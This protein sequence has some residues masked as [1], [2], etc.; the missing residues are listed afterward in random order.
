[1]KSFFWALSLAA[2][3]FVPLNV[4]AENIYKEGGFHYESYLKTHPVLGRSITPIFIFSE[5]REEFLSSLNQASFLES[6]IHLTTISQYFSQL[7][8]DAKQHGVTAYTLG[9][10][11]VVGNEERE[12]TC[13]I[14][15]AHAFSRD[16]GETLIHEAMHCKTFSDIRL[17][18]SA[19]MKASNLYA[20]TSEL[21]GPQFL[22]L[23]H[24]VLA[25]YLQISFVAN[26]LTDQGDL[27]V[28]RAAAAKENKAVSIGY[29][30]ARNALDLCSL[31]RSCPVETEEIIDLILKSKKLTDST[32][33]DIMELHKAAVKSGYVFA[34][35]N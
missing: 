12:T 11:A 4:A 14:V 22:S 23:F 34:D 33:A 32:V 13:G 30:T 28:K 3:G 25:A 7:K 31:P 27:M 2:F 35:Q 8:P 15:V 21:T 19:K 20:L 24:E 10:K 5:D 26:G 1:M 16:I 9:G 6:G 29:R 18:H 17:S